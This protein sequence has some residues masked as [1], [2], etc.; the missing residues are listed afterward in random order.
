MSTIL[1][2]A[3]HNAFRRPEAL[4]SQ[5]RCHDLKIWVDTASQFTN[6]LDD[7]G[8]PHQKSRHELIIQ[9]PTNEFDG[10]QL[11]I[12]ME[13][14]KGGKK[15]GKDSYDVT[16]GSIAIP[17]GHFKP[18]KAFPG[19]CQKVD[20]DIMYRQVEPGSKTNVWFLLQTLDCSSDE[21]TWSTAAVCRGMEYPPSTSVTPKFYTRAPTNMDP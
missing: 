4:S 1:R 13:T 5:Q 11:T 17:L 2:T 8:H 16:F 6:F 21:P 12:I 10:M 9:A 3:L 19:L 18:T 15:K 14:I 7:A 20:A